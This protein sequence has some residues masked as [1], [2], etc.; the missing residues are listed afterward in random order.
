MPHQRPLVYAVH[1]VLTGG[2]NFRAMWRAAAVA[3]DTAFGSR[4]FSNAV[5][6]RGWRWFRD[7]ALILSVT[8]LSGTAAGDGW[9]RAGPLPDFPGTTGE[10]VKTVPVGSLS[11]AVA[12]AV[13][14]D[15]LILGGTYDLDNRVAI[16]RPGNPT[17]P[18]VLRAQRLG[19]AVIRVAAVEGF[20]VRA[21]YWI[22]ENLVVVG[23][24]P[25]DADCEHGF[26]IV[27]PAT[28]VA[29]RNNCLV[30]FNAHIKV[31]RE[32][33][34]FPDSGL[35]EHNTL[36]EHRARVTSNPVTP[37]DIVA[38]SNWVVRANLIMDFAKS[39]GNRTSYGAFM[40][41]SG[42]QGV[43]DAN[44]VACRYQVA[45]VSLNEERVGLS[46]G[47]GGTSPP[48][49]CR[50]DL[51]AIEH[52]GGVMRDNLIL[53]CSDVGIYLNKAQ[54]IRVTDNILEHTGGLS[55]RFPVTDAEV[56]NNILDG[57]LHEYEGARLAGRNNIMA[58]S[59]DDTGQRVVADRATVC[60]R[61][62]QF[63]PP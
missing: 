32:G 7:L 8:T 43:F 57:G 38:A 33:Q 56:S 18:I 3:A 34:D 44:I 62:D 27:G 16:T 20:L 41:G 28:T 55:A 5:L 39:S 54:Q 40:K 30:D 31:N 59:V 23:T 45:P 15:T 63:V 2:Q 9:S 47:G 19:G 26:H 6:L 37:I 49:L 25:Q 58:I 51:C 36:Y 42:R 60:G 22:F 13:P 52:L 24:C 4:N 11:A 17:A 50:D 29:I 14:G 46:F 21:P 12:A 48:M 1:E 53:E 10:T 61:V 35:I